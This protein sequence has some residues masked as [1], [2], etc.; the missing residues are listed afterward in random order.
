[1]EFFGRVF[2][3]GQTA[4]HSDVFVLR[5]NFEARNPGTF[6]ARCLPDVVAS[7]HIVPKARMGSE[8]INRRRDMSAKVA[9]APL[10]IR[11]IVVHETC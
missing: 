10:R 8:R 7:L 1:L 9:D 5:G 11:E 2:P 4:V 6:L 3:I